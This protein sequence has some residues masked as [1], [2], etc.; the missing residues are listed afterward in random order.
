[1]E[2]SSTSKQSTALPGTPRAGNTAKAPAPRGARQSPGPEQHSPSMG[3][4]R[5]NHPVCLA[6][7]GCCSPTS[8]LPVAQV[9]GNDEHPSLPCTHVQEATVQSLDH[10]V[11]P[12][13]YLLGLLIVVAA[14]GTEETVQVRTAPQI[15]W[16][17]LKSQPFHP[18]M[19]QNPTSSIL[20]CHEVPH[21][22]CHGH[23][24][25]TVSLEPSSLLPCGRCSSTVAEQMVPLPAHPQLSASRGL[26]PGRKGMLRAHTRR[27]GGCHPAGSSCSGSGQS[28][29]CGW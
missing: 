8:A 6:H 3:P 19:A 21:P 17:T 1:M 7:L 14:A 4:A 28:R 10:L 2:I 5:L 15:Q 11:G 26:A 18:T 16:A 22:P 27:R 29:G 12:Q 9:W 20:V 24:H 25:P 23:V 13:S